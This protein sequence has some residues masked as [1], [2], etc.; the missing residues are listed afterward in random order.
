MATATKTTRSA[1]TLI[2][3]LVVIAIIALLVSILTPYLT[4]ARE[5]ARRAVCMSNLRNIATAAHGFAN[6]HS[7]RFPGGA[8]DIGGGNGVGWVDILN[9]EWYRSTVIA[10]FFWRWPLPSSSKSC[11]MCP[12]TRP[13]PGRSS[14]PYQYDS[15]AAGAY[16]G[17]LATYKTAPPPQ[18]GMEI[19]PTRVQTLYSEYW[20][21]TTRT[22][23]EYHLG[24]LVEKFPRP[25]YTYLIWE[26]EYNGLDAGNAWPFTPTSV[27]INAGMNSTI[28]PWCAQAGG[29]VAEF[30]AFRH[31]LPPDLGMYQKQATMCVLFVDGH[32]AVMGPNEDVCSAGRLLVNPGS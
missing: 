14:T 16:D 20:G 11:L 30:F 7:N 25:Y 21:T 1:F 13:W 18:Y 9:A 29:G 26:S 17:S 27:T 24:T 6:T 22:L 10:D 2:E 4:K 23:G 8:L 31:T 19:D 32:V 28:A 5:I 12:D 3:L 15:D